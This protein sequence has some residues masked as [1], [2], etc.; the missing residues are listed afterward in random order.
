MMLSTQWVALAREASLAA[1][2]VAIGLTA[3]RRAQIG[4][5]GTYTHSFF[6]LTIGTERILKLILVLDFMLDHG[7]ALPDDK[8][9]KSKGHDI[10][11]L[12]LEA[13]AVAGRRSLAL[14]YPFPSNTITSAMI[15][16]LT[17]FAKSSRYYNLDYLT[18]GKSKAIGDPIA[19][20][21][22][23]VGAPILA[24]HYKAKSEAKD[25]RLATEAE[26][27]LGASTKVMFT[28]EDGASINSVEEMFIH[29][30]K[31]REIQRWGQFHAFTLIRS[32]A[33]QL[34]TLGYEAQSKG[35]DV[36]ALS[37]FFRVFYNDDAYAKSVKTW[38]I[39]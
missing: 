22:S 8:Y 28:R 33:E 25:R 26:A 37:D 5:T 3:L 2:S 1:E 36:P 4:N 20:W 31:T 15:R 32:L 18:N 7:G 10:A 27:K 35:F 12:I 13:Q 23:D 6:Q 9:L 24:Q 11:G 17:D 21:Y 14:R 29:T 38:K 34:T 16:V 30:A 19:A 39:I